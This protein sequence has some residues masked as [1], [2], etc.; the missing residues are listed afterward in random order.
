[1]PAGVYVKYDDPQRRQEIVS[2]RLERRY[3]SV[4]PPSTT[5]VCP[6]MLRAAGDIRKAA[7]P[8]TSSMLITAPLGI[9]LSMIS[10]IT[11][12]SLM[13]FVLAWAAICL[14]TSGVRTRSEEHTSEL[15]AR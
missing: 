9:G 5:M 7:M 15:Q 13:L 10:S 3:G 4:Q 2:P 6:V 1:M 12:S 14:S 11:S 8:A